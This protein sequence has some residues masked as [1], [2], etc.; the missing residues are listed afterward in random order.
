MSAIRVK[1][2]GITTPDDAQQA[3]AAGADAIG[4][5]FFPQSPRSVTPE[6][7]AAIIR[8]LPPFLDTVGV[9]VNLKVR[10]A[11]AVAYQLA[12]GSIQ[13]LGDPADLEDSFP[14]RRIAAFRIR[15]R[16]SLRDAEEFLRRAPRPAAVLV[17]AYVAGQWGGTGQ[18][19][20]WELL[21]EFR[22]GVPLILAGGLTPDNV[23]EAIR[24]VQPDGV[25]VATGV[26]TSPGRKDA[27]LMR[28]F[29]AAV[30]EVR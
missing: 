14:F 21:R 18:T 8:A 13:L 5:N 11:C 9:F 3:Y 20:P 15:D 4:F 16:D 10:Q 7:A 6:R 2:C 12:L 28:R 22:P 19:A 27:E 30:K 26:E 23:A 25:D 17:D 29:V 24:Q 1:I